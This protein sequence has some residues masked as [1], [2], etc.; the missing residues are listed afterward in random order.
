MALLV[1]H[2]LALLLRDLYK[3]FYEKSSLFSC[4]GLWMFKESIKKPVHRSVQALCGTSSGE[5]GGTFSPG[6]FS[7]L[8]GTL[9]SCDTWDS[10]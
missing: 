8:Y 5:F 9:A 7:V 10:L 1:W 6:L 3:G 4:I 2:F